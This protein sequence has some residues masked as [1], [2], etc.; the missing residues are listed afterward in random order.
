MDKAEAYKIAQRQL[1][2]VENNSYENAYFKVN[3][4][5]QSEVTGAAG[6]SYE[7]ELFYTWGNKEKNSIKVACSVTTKNWYQHEQL[8][9]SITICKR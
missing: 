1:L 2:I 6:V 3:S 7:V 4:K 5:S 9:E 8:T